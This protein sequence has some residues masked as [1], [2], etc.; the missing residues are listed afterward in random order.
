MNKVTL[1]S[2]MDMLQSVSLI[3]GMAFICFQVYNMSRSYRADQMVK[4][5]DF[6]MKISEELR[7]ARY[8]KITNAIQDHDGKYPILATKVHQGF[9]EHLL[10][11]YL[12]N[13]ETLGNLVK[14]GVITKKMAYNE[15]SYDVEAAWSNEDVRRFIRDQ[16]KEN[17]VRDREDAFY[18]G[19]EYLARECF[20]QDGKPLPGLDKE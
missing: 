8:D 15:L 2:S 18:T 7:K 12:G 17:K 9:P 6:V 10:D 3:L 13:F 14:D 4:S 19:F 16:R 20:K 5:A 1:K 11:E